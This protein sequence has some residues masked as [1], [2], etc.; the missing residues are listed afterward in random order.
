MASRQDF[1]EAEWDALQKGATGSGML[2][3]LS[4]RDLSDTFGEM[5][6]MAKYM[7]GQQAASSSELVRELAKT[8]GTGFGLTTSPDR[9]RS[10]TMDSLRSAVAILTAKAPAD[11]DAYRQFVLGLADAV[12]QAKGGVTPVEASTIAAIREGLGAA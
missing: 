1:S 12:A 3:S 2:V 7:A 10:E 11:L 6:A 4:D 8:H 5:G 9:V